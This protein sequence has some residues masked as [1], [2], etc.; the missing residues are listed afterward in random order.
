V[1]SVQDE[2]A[3]H[4]PFTMALQA[5]L[6]PKLWFG[7]LPGGGDAAFLIRNRRKLCYRD[8]IPNT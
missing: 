2:D 5:A 6:D 8:L 1:V 4:G 3:A 7:V